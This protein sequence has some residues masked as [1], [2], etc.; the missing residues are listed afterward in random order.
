MIFAPQA[1]T[2]E[3]HPGP[4]K[5]LLIFRGWNRRRRPG[6]PTW[7]KTRSRRGQTDS[8]TQ[9][10]KTEEPTLPDA[11]GGGN[12][13]RKQMAPPPPENGRRSGRNLSFPTAKPEE[14]GSEASERGRVPS[15][16]RLCRARGGKGPRQDRNES[17]APLF[18]HGEDPLGGPLEGKA[19]SREPGQGGRGERAALAR[20]VGRSPV[21]KGENPPE[22]ECP[23]KTP[24][25]SAGM[26]AVSTMPG[27]ST[28]VPTP[29]AAGAAG[30]VQQMCH[31]P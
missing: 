16:V 8:K 30:G 28:S 19:E 27:G 15:R 22:A 10:A 21:E 9:E 26:V 25:P 6:R 7:G 2:C 31:L 13:Q 14:R 3:N 5:H 17:G 12:E 23:P 1:A 11:N 24:L 20:H 18:R 29:R 4:R